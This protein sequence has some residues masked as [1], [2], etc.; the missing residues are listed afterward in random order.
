MGL[1]GHGYVEVGGVVSACCSIVLRS[2]TG[3]G[4]LEGMFSCGW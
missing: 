4:G 1:S 3:V 2:S